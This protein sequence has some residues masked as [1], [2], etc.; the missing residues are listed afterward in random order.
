MNLKATIFP[1]QDKLYDY[2]QPL[3]AD[4][5][6]SSQE[7]LEVINDDDRQQAEV[8]EISETEENDVEMLAED[9]S[10]ER[11]DE[12]DKSNCMGEDTENLLQS[13]EMPE[14]EN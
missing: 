13:Q 11:G 4:T 7:E 2:W 5:L 8:E 6:S 1:L 14:L 3:S 9:D 10:E 12:M